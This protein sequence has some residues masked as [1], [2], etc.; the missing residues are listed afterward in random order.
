ML[1]FAAMMVFSTTSTNDGLTQ[2]LSAE[3]VQILWQDATTTLVEVL[4][5]I[6]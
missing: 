2:P 6:F 4:L 3:E 1:P 5:T